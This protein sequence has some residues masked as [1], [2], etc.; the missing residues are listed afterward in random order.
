MCLLSGF[1]GFCSCNGSSNSGFFRIDNNVSVHFGSRCS[2]CCCIVNGSLSLDANLCLL[3]GFTG[4]CTRNGG[5]DSGF[6]RIDRSVSV[7]FGSRCSVCC[8]IVNGSLSL[9]ANLCL[10]SGFTGFCTRNGGSDSRFFRIDRSVSVYFGNRLSGNGLSINS[11]WCLLS[12]FT[13]F[14]TRNGGSD[15]CF[16]RIDRSVSVHFGNRLRGNGLSINS[17][18]CLLSG[19]TGFC[20][21]NGSSDSIFLICIL[22]R[23]LISVGLLLLH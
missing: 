14:C 19:F 13:G 1:T 12:G 7:Y 5:S 9:D 20:T 16:F 15:S 21:R 6:F 17:C 10:L 4:F 8:C 11:R 18:W 3:S 23:W 22:R 2:V